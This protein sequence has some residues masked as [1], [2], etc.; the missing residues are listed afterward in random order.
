MTEPEILRRCKVCGAAS[1]PGA[2]FC[3][4]CGNATG[5]SGAF[6]VPFA[7]TQDLRSAVPFDK[8][9]DLRSA[10]PIDETQD[11]RSGVPID[12]TQDL[13]SGVPF[14]ETQDLRSR[15]PLNPA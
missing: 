7:E 13:R 6:D 3:S 1:R 15:A 2:V 5:K 10:V 14:D 8:T 4:Q 9:Q 12:E 11:L